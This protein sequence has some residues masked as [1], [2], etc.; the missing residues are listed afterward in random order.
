VIGRAM[1]AEIPPGAL[2]FWRWSV[3]AAVLLPLAGASTWALRRELV[4]NWV[5]LTTLALSGVLGF[6]Y[7][8]YRGLQTTSA[9]NGVL[10]IA[11]IPVL[12]PAIEYAVDRTVLTRRQALGIGVSLAG[13]VI[14]ISR[15]RLD[16]FARLDL[17]PGDGW[18][19]LAAP[20]WAV[21][22]VVVKRR[23]PNLPPLVLLLGT[24]LVGMVFVAPLYAWEG[25]SGVSFELMSPSV[26]LTIAYVGVVA[27][28]LAFACW[29]SGV[30]RVGA[31]KAGSF[32]HAMPV[33]AAI[34]A[35]V[36]LGERLAGF[37]AIGIA[38][39]ACGLAL[40]STS[41]AKSARSIAG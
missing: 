14:V 15:G 39:V 9:I 3:A 27:S 38:L 26:I 12:I 16:A 19:A 22:S 28:V 4:R 8:V 40:S 6:Q 24:V 2:T 30:A 11:T 34:L 23:P 37:H 25:T 41:R 21:Y 1:H 31:A 7:F 20:M 32:I 13:V 35:I 10:I 36:F 17:T 5:L 33:F 18:M 29:N